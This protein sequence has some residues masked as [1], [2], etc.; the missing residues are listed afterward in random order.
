[1][2]LILPLP[3]LYAIYIDISVALNLSY[4]LEIHWCLDLEKPSSD[5]K[6]R[7]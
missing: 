5:L 3:L 4:L 7:L 1:M 6:E 2:G